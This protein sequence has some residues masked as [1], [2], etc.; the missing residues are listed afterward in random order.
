[1]WEK[2]ATAYA[3]TF[4]HVTGQ[5]VDALLDGAG[6][7]RQQI[8]QAKAVY[9]VSP[10]SFPA[11]NKAAH[12]NPTCTPDESLYIGKVAEVSVQSL[13]ATPSRLRPHPWKALCACRSSR[14][15]S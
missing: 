9:S 5:A 15:R 8:A 4:G 13:R 3:K 6:V 10:A 1:M 7:E 2:G 11:H 14:T 12:P